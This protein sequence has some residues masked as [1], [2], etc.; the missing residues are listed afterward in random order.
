MNEPFE[1]H[2]LQ[3]HRFPSS[4]FLTGATGIALFSP[5]LLLY[6]LCEKCPNM[7]ETRHYLQLRLA[8]RLFEVNLIE[9]RKTKSFC[10]KVDFSDCRS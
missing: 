10:M 8:D 4:L 1:V 9:M 5:G 6:E 3:S 2:C 7:S